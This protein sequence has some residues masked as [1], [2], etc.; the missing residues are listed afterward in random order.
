MDEI[1]EATLLFWLPLAFIPLG[2]WFSQIKPPSIGAKIGTFVSL[3]GLALVLASPW[4]VPESPSSAVGHLLGFIAGPTI[5]ILIGLFKGCLFWKCS[6]GKTT[7]KRSKFRRIA[8]SFR[9]NLVFT[10]ALVGNNSYH[11]FW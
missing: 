2:L 10:N 1:L 6:C 4:T 11:E 8:F 3:I 5:M 7:V 9:I